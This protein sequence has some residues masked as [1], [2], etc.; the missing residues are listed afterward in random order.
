MSAKSNPNQNTALVLDQ[1]A[2][3]GVTKYLAGVKSLTL[4]S[5]SYT[6]ATLKAQLQAEMDAV[7]ALNQSRAQYKQQ[8]VATRLARTK[9]SAVRKALKTYVLSTYGV[10]A[11]QVFEDFGMS[12]PKPTG[13]RTAKSKAQAA[14]KATA[15]KQAKKVAVE[16]I[17]SPA[18]NAPALPPASAPAQPAAA[19][20]PKS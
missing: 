14:D 11:V 4:A 2:I 6:P 9:G 15:K 17:D 3:D 8:V 1:K 5:T 16:S 18:P 13:Q 12:V 19:T 7:K 10:D 20:P